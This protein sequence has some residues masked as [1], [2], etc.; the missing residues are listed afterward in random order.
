MGAFEGP[1]LCTRHKF[2]HLRAVRH[3]KEHAGIPGHHM[4]LQDG[5]TGS[6]GDGDELFTFRAWFHVVSPQSH[7]ATGI[8]HHV[9]EAAEKQ[10]V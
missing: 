7:A 5:R 4:E 1:I 3:P 10:R 6:V 9:L 2:H 8:R